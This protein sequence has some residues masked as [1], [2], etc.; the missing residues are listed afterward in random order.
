MNRP[1]LSLVFPAFNEANNLPA[2]LESALK[3]G[4]LLGLDFEVVVVD[5]G[6]H[7][8][9]ANLL[10]AWCRRDPRIHA[11]HHSDNQG[12]GA[13][14]KRGLRAARGE[15]VF[16]SDADLQFD[17]SEIRFLLNHAEEFEIVA[18]Y[19]APR[20]DPWARRLIAAVWG[21]LVD[22]LFDL[23]V[24][25]IDCAFKVFHRE[26]L[27]AIPIES[28]GAFVNT[29]ILARARAAGFRIKQIPVTHQARSEGRQT[30]A[31]PRV[32]AR[33]LIELTLLYSALHP[34]RRKPK[35]EASS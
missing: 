32:I 9:S 12:Y 27:D 3:T 30:G 20:R 5:D 2:L 15:L 19:R 24:R 8:E 18:G 10:A 4:Q 29:E 33:A 14:L 6:S 1:T 25:D 13:A 21:R 23:R 35:L 22:L 17:L 28:I 31:N 26:V 16:F 34:R 11:V 7:D